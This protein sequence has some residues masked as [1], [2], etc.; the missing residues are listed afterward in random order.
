MVVW[1]FQSQSKA[2]LLQLLLLLLMAVLSVC[3]LYKHHF[4]GSN[5][6]QN[7][8]YWSWRQAYLLYHRPKI[9]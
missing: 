1:L 8:S 6:T 4:N 7:R 3:C 2:R 5:S 9:G